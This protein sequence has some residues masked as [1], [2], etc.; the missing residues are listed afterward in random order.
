[1]LPDQPGGAA[2]VSAPGHVPTSDILPSTAKVSGLRRRPTGAPPPLPRKLGWSGKL[3]LALAVLLAVALVWLSPQDQPQAATD[4][5]TAILR[6]FASLRTAWLT[7]PMRAVA[8]LG[9]AWSVTIL[10]GALVLALIVFKRWRHLATFLLYLTFLGLVGTGVSFLTKRPRPYGVTIIGD[11]IGFSLPSFPVAILAACLM[12]IAYSLV[13]P[14]RPRTLAKLVIAVVL[15]VVAF[16]RLYL[17]VDHPTDVVWAIVAGVAVP[18]GAF[19]WFTPNEAFPVTYRR[20]KTA[21][22]DVTGARG[23]AIRQAVQEQL[24]LTVL[25]IKPIGLAASGG[26][27]PL[28]LRVAGEPDSYV[29]A[30]LYAKS[31]VRADRWY[32][33]G[34]MILYGSLEDETSFQNVRRFVQYED[35]TLRLM[36]DAKLPVP[37]PYG[38]VEIT[39]EREYL[40][41]MEFFDGAVE[42]SDAEVDDRIIDEGLLLVR[43]MWNAGLAHR[44]IKPGNLMVRDDRV[45]LV[46]AFFVQVR[47]SPW[48]QAVDLGNMMLV[49][50]VGS[51]PERVYQHAL[52]YFTPEEI[53]EAFAATRGVASPSQLRLMIKQDPRDLLGQFRR[54]APARRLIPIQ[55]WSVKRVALALGV[56]VTGLALAG[57]TYGLLTPFRGVDVPDSP[58]CNPQS[59]TVLVAQ[60]VPDATTIPCVLGLPSG[61]NSEGG[62]VQSGEAEFTLSSGAEGSQ[63]VAVTLA[64]TCDVAAAQAVD[65]DQP[66]VERF[67][68][69]PRRLYRFPGG[70]VTYE[71]SG[72]ARDDRQ[73]QALADATL[74]FVPRDRVA[75][76]VRDQ[77]GL[78]LCGAGVRCPGG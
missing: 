42:I 13:V 55:R 41:A 14:G 5:E 60:A 75:A 30:K 58:T 19:R 64:R 32:K 34:R 35:Y 78:A 56:L 62:T 24:G 15:V 40:I 69:G 33:L 27:T 20:G 16:A 72:S 45:L 52:Q 74:D 36:Q 39:P 68:A 70:C 47:P 1:M 43:K 11:W 71:F 46:D 7:P 29:F 22:L 76:Y 8:T 67:D 73:L 12:G 3:W 18:L 49:L 6:W 21:H 38:I 2:A 17:A 48:R 59:T 66:G 51:T 63:V 57:F 26:S 10:G 53:A 9:T 61:W 65:S 37:A 50:A 23:E 44:D 54:L 28:R 31:H 4:A 77:T 25:E